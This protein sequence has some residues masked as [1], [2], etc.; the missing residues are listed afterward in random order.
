M[1]L[2]DLLSRIAGEHTVWG[3]T[4]TAKA[5]Y[6][7]KDKPAAQLQVW[8]KVIQKLVKQMV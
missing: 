1:K 5:I 8:G 2:A 6:Y 3:P 7:D 4:Y